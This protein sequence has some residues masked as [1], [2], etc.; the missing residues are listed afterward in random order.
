VHFSAVTRYALLTGG[1]N[2]FPGGRSLRD[3]G[4]WRTVAVIF[5]SFAGLAAIGWFA[6][7]RGS[8]SAPLGTAAAGRAATGLIA[9]MFVGTY[10]GKVSRSRW[11][12]LP[13]GAVAAA[14]ITR[15]AVPGA[16]RAK[17]QVAT[18]RTTKVL[19]MKN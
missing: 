18:A 15:L 7:P 19:G 14:T 3:A 5:G 13:A 4:G 1:R 16:L 2:L 12:A 8:T 11:Y 10:L 9:A 17:R 6:Q